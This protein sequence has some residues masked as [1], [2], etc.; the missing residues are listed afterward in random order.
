[1]FRCSAVF[2]LAETEVCEANYH[3]YFLYYL[4]MSYVDVDFNEDIIIERNVELV[5]ALN[6]ELVKT[7]NNLQKINKLMKHKKNL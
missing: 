1:M 6:N 3:Y 5:I 4:Y 2:L 7:I